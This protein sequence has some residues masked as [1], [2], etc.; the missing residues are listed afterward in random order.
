MFKRRVGPAP[1]PGSG[2]AGA[3]G[4]P[5]I[6]ELDS[7]DFAIIGTERTS[8]LRPHL[9]KGAFLDDGESIVVIPRHVLVKAKGSIP[10]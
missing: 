1:V 9:P 4:C 7:G 3:N 8:Q 6:W 10:D 2:S 5:D